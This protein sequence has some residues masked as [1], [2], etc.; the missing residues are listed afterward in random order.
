[1]R[2]FFL[3][4]LLGTLKPRE[5]R[6]PLVPV[7]LLRLVRL[8]GACSV[9]VPVVFGVISATIV[10]GCGKSA[11]RSL[12]SIAQELAPVMPPG[13]R[14]AVS[15][16]TIRFQ[17]ETGYPLFDGGGN[18]VRTA[19]VD[20]VLSFVP[21]L[22]AA[23]YQRQREARRSVE[24]ALASAATNSAEYAQAQQRRARCPV[25]VFY[26]DDYSVYVERP[27]GRLDDPSPTEAALQIQQLAPLFRKTFH[28]YGE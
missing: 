18:L 6:A 23:E 11:P 8:V 22:S 19:R 24:Q 21:R 9:V 7:P 17:S 20:V 25:P 13:F 5:R 14:S 12:E 10:A 15:N 26:T 28:A 4:S 27:V 16:A 2:H 3:I 1:M